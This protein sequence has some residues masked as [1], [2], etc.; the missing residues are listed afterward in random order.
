MLSKGVPITDMTHWLGHRDI[1]VTFRIYGLLVPSAAAGAR[2]FS[3][4]PA[5]CHP[6]PKKH[7]NKAKQE[8]GISQ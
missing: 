3:L 8:I 5:S 7:P 1:R 4:R 6:V 2:I